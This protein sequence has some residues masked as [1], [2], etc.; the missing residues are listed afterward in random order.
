MSWSIKDQYID[1]T[2]SRHVVVFHNRD[3]NAE[4]HLI[5]EFKFPSCPHC[6]QVNYTTQQPVD[7]NTVISNTLKQLND[8]HRT[9]LQYKESFPQVRVGTEPKK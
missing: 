2:R 7:F 6:G 8:H 4:H 9:V 1:L 3:T 5:N